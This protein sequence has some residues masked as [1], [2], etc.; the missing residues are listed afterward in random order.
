[1]LQTLHHAA[2]GDVRFTRAHG[3]RKKKKKHRENIK[4]VCVCVCYYRARV[5]I[6]SSSD[7]YNNII[8]LSRALARTAQST[9]IMA[10]RMGIAFSGRKVGS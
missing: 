10:I 8:I 6:L 3:Q 4:H 2:A 1:M 5:I 7:G 9:E